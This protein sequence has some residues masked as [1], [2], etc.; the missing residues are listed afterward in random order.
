M[1]ISVEKHQDRWIVRSAYADK[2]IV[3][4]AGCR[5]NPTAR[6]WWTDQPEVAAKL[7]SGDAVA[8][9]A[10]INAER[11][12][13]HA[14][15]QAS[16]AASRAADA[17]IDIPVG[18][19][20]LRKG[21]K[22]AGYQ[23]ACVL[24][25][26]KKLGETDATRRLSANTQPIDAHPAQVG[27]G[28]VLIGDEMGVGKTIEA[29]GIINALSSIKSV[30]VV[31]PA[32]PK[33]NWS[34]ELRLWLARPMTVGIANGVVPDTDA[35]I[36][37]WEMLAK[38]RPLLDRRRWDLLVIDEAQKGKNPKAQRSVAL[39]GKWDKDPA[40]R[41]A[42]L[43]A[44]RRIWLT[45]TPWINR[46]KELW[47]MLKMADPKGLGSNWQRYHVRYCEGHKDGYGWKIDGASNL[48]EL[49]AKLR[50]TLMI[51]RLK[52]DVLAELPP[53]RRQVIALQIQDAATQ[54]L[55]DHE[56]ELHERVEMARRAVAAASSDPEAY[57][58]AIRQLEEAE[59]VAFEE[60]SRVRH[61]VALAKLPQVI[62]H[63]EEVLE[64]VD[65]L[66]VMG[67]HHD[68]MNA[69][70]AHFRPSM[71][72]AK[73]TGEVP[74]SRRQAEVDRFQE[75]ARCRL[76]VG[77]ITA[78]GVAITLT[79]ASM[80]VFPELDVVPGNL[81]QAEDRCHRKG[82]TD[83]VLIQHLV[84][85]GSYDMRM[86]EIVIEK[87]R[88]FDAGLDNRAADNVAAPAPIAPAKAR[89]PVAP[90]DDDLTPDQIEAV[91]EALKRLAGLCDGAFAEDGMGFNKLDTDFGHDLAQAE[92]LSQK[93]A[94]AGRKIVIKYQ[95][96]YP[97]DLLAR[98]KGEAK[99]TSQ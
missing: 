46:P 41:V 54:A 84:L 93:Q 92:R 48:S 72:V 64:S 50:S 73:I 47:T 52:A 17:D 9:A 18:A 70:E 79:A 90:S 38:L 45:G 67:W 88:V 30:L 96:Q 20:A 6:V 36:V 59:H 4:A 2:D 75:D 1:S 66:V 51:R 89:T 57:A 53:K 58:R 29:I 71:G 33:V 42:P 19:G 13:Q 37:S 28:A 68:V 60:I 62:E 25:A 11:E 43:E 56:N 26:L 99:E 22:F 40:E 49:Q 69:I 81:S 35:V 21:F 7:S 80:V 74:V 27:S 44:R 87:Q 82:Q 94:K 10:A 76:F 32:T 91:H 86:A 61:Q 5:W 95:R 8:I 83:S 3:K 14:R 24:Y 31:C 16:I 39:Y 55:V 65:K 15:E 34:R 97:A 77:S 12:A 98:I 23:R 85:E 78:A 63:L